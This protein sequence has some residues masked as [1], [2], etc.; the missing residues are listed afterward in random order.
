MEPGDEEAMTGQPV[1][2]VW[3]T[4]A[5]PGWPAVRCGMLYPPSDSPVNLARF[6]GALGRAF[7]GHPSGCRPAAASRTRLASFGLIDISFEVDDGRGIVPVLLYVKADRE[8]AAHFSAVRRFLEDRGERSPVYFA[9]SRLPDAA[10]GNPFRPFHAGDLKRWTAEIPNGEYAMWWPASSGEPFTGSRA[11]PHIGRAFRALDSIETYVHAALMRSLG[12]EGEGVGRLELPEES[13][14]FA[15]EGPEQ[16]LLLLNISSEKGIR[17][18]FPLKGSSTAYR[19]A[20][21]QVFAGYAEFWKNA[22]VEKGFATD[23]AGARSPLGW[24]LASAELTGREEAKGSSLSA[25]GA[26]ALGR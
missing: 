23:P 15:L 4:N 12:Y 2:I 13:A 8:E 20:F 16:K 7:E 10:P 14:I 22:A 19:D 6:G 9:P 21:W 26:T 5:P 25:F 17:F 1:D 18:Q 11:F 3:A 24:W